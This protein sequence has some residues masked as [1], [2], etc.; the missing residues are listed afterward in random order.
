MNNDYMRQAFLRL[1]KSGR[2]QEPHGH[3]L[4]CTNPSWIKYQNPIN[5]VYSSPIFAV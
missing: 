1:K 5:E 4:L 2:V 3:M